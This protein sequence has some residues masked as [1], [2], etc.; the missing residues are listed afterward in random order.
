M[1][2]GP[3]ILDCVGKTP[4]VRLGGAELREKGPDLGQTGTS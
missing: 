2:N 3:T 4:M 1:R